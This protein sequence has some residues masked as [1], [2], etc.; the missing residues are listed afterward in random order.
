M[1]QKQQIKEGNTSDLLKLDH[2]SYSLHSTKKNMVKLIDARTDTHRHTHARN[3]THPVMHGT[4]IKTVHAKRLN[5]QK[6]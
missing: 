3:H 1:V 4:L 5:H 6:Y 2:I